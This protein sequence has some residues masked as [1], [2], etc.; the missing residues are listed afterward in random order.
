MESK[1]SGMSTDDVY[2]PRLWYYNLLL[3]TADYE[4]KRESRSTMDD[5]CPQ[6]NNEMHE[7]GNNESQVNKIL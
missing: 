5:D 2:E 1:R 3:F 4:I 6:E 7:A